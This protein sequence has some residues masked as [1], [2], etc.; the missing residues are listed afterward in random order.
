[1]CVNFQIGL[2]SL[3]LCILYS[4]FSLFFEI[5]KI[6]KFTDKTTN[7]I[8]KEYPNKTNQKVRLLYTKVIELKCIAFV[9][10]CVVVLL[11]YDV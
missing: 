4:S 1:M 2:L 8:R 10:S 6:L 3:S 7:S 11:V 9:V 5:K